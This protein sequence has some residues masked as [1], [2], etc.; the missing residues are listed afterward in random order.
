[1]ERAEWQR[2]FFE[3]CPD[4]LSAHAEDGAFLSASS[5]ADSVL[6][7][8]PD[9]LIGQ[10]L[11]ELVHPE[12]SEHLSGCWTKALATPQAPAAAILARYRLRQP[13]GDHCWVESSLRRAKTDGALMACITRRAPLHQ[14]PSI[15]YSEPEPR[16]QAATHRDHVVTMMPGLVWYGPVSADLSRYR[17][18]YMSRYLEKI[19]GYTPEEWIRTPGFWLSILHPEDKERAVQSARSAFTGEAGMQPYRIKTKD[20]GV[21]WVQSFVSIE[22]DAHGTPVRMHGLS[23]DVT[24][25]KEA[26][27]RV[28]QL[29]YRA[30][31]LNER[32]DA[33]VENVPGI[34]WE[35]WER[36]SQTAGS[37]FCSIHLTDLI[38]YTPQEW[39][40]LPSGWLDLVPEEDQ[41]D[42]QA[43]LQRLREQGGS[44]TLH[45]RV[46]SKDGKKYWLENHI[47]LVRNSADEAVAMRG[48][49]LDITAE[50]QVEQERERLRI[51]NQRQAE[52]IAELSTPLIPITDKIVVLPLLGALDMS[53][54]E[55]IVHSLLRGV[56]QLR[57]Q[58]ALIDVT[59]VVELDANSAGV[60]IRA[61]NALRL[62]GAK[63]LITG[64]RPE[65]AKMLIDLGVPL[66]D[67]ATRASL[68]SALAELLAIPAVPRRR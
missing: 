42:F 3:E 58:L 48:V 45:H 53:R 11:H 36:N 61:A 17:I 37:D 55:Q 10:R 39:I 52:R 27:L 18:S 56:V 19:A 34:V 44:A 41:A 35:R 29:L 1:M 43:G 40:A 31:E 62:V 38:G 32:I 54:A 8:S 68:K 21:V 20:G 26:E 15:V 25:Y 49:A 64:M 28:A 2:F 23:L 5:A 65:M 66:Q 22:R 33:L 6:G 50:K 13:S 9:A 51:E 7:W 24:R 60:L 30:N 12:D 47:A 67:L 4:V 63:A 16:L 14:Q 57:A 59:G 46:R